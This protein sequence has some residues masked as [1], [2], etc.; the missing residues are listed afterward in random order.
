MI[1]YIHT[2]YYWIRGLFTNMIRKKRRKRKTRFDSDAKL[3]STAFMYLR[4]PRCTCAA[5]QECFTF[6]FYYLTLRIE[7]ERAEDVDKRE[8]SV[9]YIYFF[10]FHNDDDQRTFENNHRR[11][12]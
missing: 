12:N 5:E 9:I 3:L 11:N 4:A 10:F 1:D 8:Y 2:I 7:N 6:S